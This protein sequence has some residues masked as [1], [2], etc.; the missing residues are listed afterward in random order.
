VIQYSNIHMATNRPTQP[1]IVSTVR[2]LNR[3]TDAD[4]TI[5]GLFS[6]KFLNISLITS[7]KVVTFL[8]EACFCMVKVALRH[9]AQG[10]FS[11]YR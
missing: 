5:I 1:G 7:E 4:E 9:V 11:S 6:V 3:K 10:R 8:P 2:G